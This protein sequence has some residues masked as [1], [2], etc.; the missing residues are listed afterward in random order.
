MDLYLHLD[1]LCMYLYGT[2][3]G[4]TARVLRGVVHE[5]CSPQNQVAWPLAVLSSGLSAFRFPL[6]A[7]IDAP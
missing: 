4:Q 5:A 3:D 6:S 1:A 7:S 2:P